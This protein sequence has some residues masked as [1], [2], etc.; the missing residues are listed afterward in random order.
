MG[1]IYIKYVSLCEFGMFEFDHHALSLSAPSIVEGRLIC[2][3]KHYS[4]FTPQEQ[5]ISC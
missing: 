3:Y 1:K 2:I 5:Y 4:F